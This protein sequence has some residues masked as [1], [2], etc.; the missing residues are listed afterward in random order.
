MI[1]EV[2][3]ASA[4]TWEKKVDGAKAGIDAAEAAKTAADAGLESATAKLDAQTAAVKEAKD[5][6]GANFTAEKEAE[7]ALKK[8]SAEVATFDSEQA[9]KA[10]EKEADEL[11]YKNDFEKLKAGEVAGKAEMNKSCGHVS[12]LIGKLSPDGSLKEALPSALLKKP[13]QRGSFDEIVV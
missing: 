4:A 10:K 13:D 3:A 6:L 8:A 2:L 12:K 9:Q 1:G 7:K 5:L 11:V